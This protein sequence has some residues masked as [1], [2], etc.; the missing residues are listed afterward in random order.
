MTNQLDLIIG[1]TL[2]L[3]IQLTSCQD[4]QEVQQKCCSEGQ[5]SAQSGNC[6]T[7]F[8][9]HQDLNQPWNEYC[10]SV[11]SGC[12]GAKRDE[13]FCGQGKE[14]AEMGG[15]CAN[16]PVIH[17]GSETVY[18]CCSACIAGMDSAKSSGTC[19]MQAMNIEDSAYSSCCNTVLEGIRTSAVRNEGSEDESAENIVDEIGPLPAPSASNE[20]VI[21]EEPEETVAE[22]CEKCSQGCAD[23]PDSKPICTCATGFELD[24]EDE[25]TCHDRDECLENPCKEDEICQN[26]EG[27][28]DCILPLSS[29]TESHSCQ[30][31]EVF[32][33]TTQTCVRKF[34]IFIPLKSTILLSS[35][36]G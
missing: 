33:P 32:D 11:F 8:V 13:S 28:F 22:F 6:E 14:I 34:D 20:T 12:C 27:G 30:P 23:G 36:Y 18:R 19:V 10:F 2:L 21:S 24:H 9:P 16:F 25:K 35:R 7:S 4:P 29:G 17:V 1:F 3:L 26:L 31:G 15:D 5:F